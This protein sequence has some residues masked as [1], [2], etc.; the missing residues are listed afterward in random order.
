QATVA[1]LAGLLML[2]GAA[3]AQEKAADAK[4]SP[5]VVLL[6]QDAATFQHNGAFELAIEEWGK[7][8]NAHP[9]DPLAAKAQYYLGVCQLQTKKYE[10]A[11]AAFAA[12][13]KNHPKFELLEDAHLN[14]AL[15][16]YSLAVAGNAAMYSQAVDSFATLVKQ[17]PKGKYV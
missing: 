13:I 5:A 17:F 6:Y 4:S 14:L 12:V 9:A 1:V 11:A 2:S 16:Q 10:P 8:L 3:H 15:S 7:L